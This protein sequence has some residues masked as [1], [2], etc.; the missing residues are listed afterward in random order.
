MKRY[1]AVLISILLVS[2][3][4]SYAQSYTNLFSEQDLRS[5]IKF[6]SDDGFEGRAPGSRGGE[7]AAK[8]IANRLQLA[9]IKPGNNLSYFQPV[10]LV[11]LK[12]DP[13][14]VLNLSRISDGKTFTFDF[15]KD[16]VGFT[17]AQKND[18]SVDGELVFVGYG[19]DAPEQNWNDY[20]GDAARYKDKI[21]VVLVNDPP[22]TEK[23]PNLFGG[24]ALTYYGRWTYK[25]EEAARKGAKGVILVH[26]DQ[27]AGYGWNVVETSFGGT[28]RFDIARTAT[29]KTPFLQFKAWMKDSSLAGFIKFGETSLSALMKKAETR[30]FQPVDLNTK[31]SIDLKAKLNRVDSNNVVGIWE[32][33]DAKLKN[34]YVIHTAHWDHLGVGKPNAKGDTIYNGALD[35][36]SGVAQIIAMAEAFTKLP[37]AEQPK[38]SQVFLFTTAEEQ[39]LL[40]AEWYAKHPVFP[41]EKTAANLN[42]D[43]GNFFG[44]TT[45]YGALGAERSSLDSIV[46]D[47]LKKRSMTFMA[48]NR[49]E[50]GSFFRSDH[51][52]FAKGGVPALSIRS[53]DDYIG[54]EKGWADK[55]FAEYNKNN[56]HQPSD[57]FDDKWQFDGMVQMLDVTF[58]IAMRVSNAPKLQAFK[59]GDEFAKAQPDRK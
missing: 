29:D 27:S 3:L 7:L 19:I 42:I 53:G 20:K 38:R 17:D 37:K 54:K 30:D 32:G 49:P 57:E 46:N 4:T 16:F 45:N 39:G 56:Y 23:E 52:P 1:F 8:Y 40:G 24:K 15:G 59:R 34:E 25:Y 36:A 5:T 11:G 31:N 22:A 47:E 6:L 2:V 21:L 35:N 18:V 28:E 10:S 12:P 43:G 44:K 48:D 41:L 51:F 55:F 13:N 50:Q 14:T 58:G 33:S 9:G 26:T